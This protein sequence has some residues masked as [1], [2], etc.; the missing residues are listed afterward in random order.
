MGAVPVPICLDHPGASQAYL[1][2]LGTDPNLGEG[3]GCVA[4]TS[5]SGQAGLDLH[6]QLTSVTPHGL[7]SKDG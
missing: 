5:L 2:I 3:Q 7:Y 4:G 1:G 6:Q